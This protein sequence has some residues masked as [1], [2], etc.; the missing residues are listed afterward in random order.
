MTE[1]KLQQCHS[2][3]CEIWNTE[4]VPISNNQQRT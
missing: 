2:I 4:N 1:I 3:K